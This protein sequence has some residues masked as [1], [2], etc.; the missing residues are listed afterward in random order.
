VV[1]EALSSG[2]QGYVLKIR[3][4]GDLLIAMEAVLEGRQFVSYVLITGKR[5]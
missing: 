1:A 4:G 3:A 5:S 2:A